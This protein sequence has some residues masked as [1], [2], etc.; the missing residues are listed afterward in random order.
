L[1]S[2]K[3]EFEDGYFRIFDPKKLVA[4]Y[5]DPDYGNLSAAKNPED[6]ILLKIKNHDTVLGGMIM[7]PLVKFKLFDTDLNTNLTEV[8]QNISRVSNHLEKWDTFLSEINNTSHYI[9]ISHTDQDMLTMTFPVTFSKPTV[10]EK[11]NLLEEI[12]PTLN[13]LEKAELL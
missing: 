3:L 10:L 4:G 13:L 2:W 6:I 1:A 11:Y 8:K 9:G 5:F 7:I 12:Y